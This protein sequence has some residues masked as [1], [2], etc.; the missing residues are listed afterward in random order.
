METLRG[1][2]LGTTIGTSGPIALAW[3]FAISVVGLWA[4]RLYNR[5]PGRWRPSSAPR[6][7]AFVNVTRRGIIESRQRSPSSS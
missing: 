3:C 2:L 5:V 1:L 4:I 7:S 6:Q